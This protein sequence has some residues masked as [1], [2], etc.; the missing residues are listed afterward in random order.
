[1]AL[2]LQAFIWGFGIAYAILG[3]FGAPNWLR[4]LIVIGV[5]VWVAWY[6]CSSRRHNRRNISGAQLRSDLKHARKT[7]LTVGERFENRFRGAHHRP[8]NEIERI[9]ERDH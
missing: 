2:L 8:R 1:M 9:Y 5:V 6:I 7:R 4:Y 3:W